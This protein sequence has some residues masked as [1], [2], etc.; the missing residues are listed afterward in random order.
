MVILEL[1]QPFP[2]HGNLRVIERRGLTKCE[3][4]LKAGSGLGDSAL[5]PQNIAQRQQHLGHTRMLAA[6]NDLA[7]LQPPPEPITGRLW[8]APGELG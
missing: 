5:L 8:I 7:D 4:A 2:W 3:C 6:M 1:S